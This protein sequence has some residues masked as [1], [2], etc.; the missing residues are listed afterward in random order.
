MHIVCPQCG[1][2]AFRVPRSLDG[3]MKIVC[4]SCGKV[5]SIDVAKPPPGN[6]VKLIMPDRGGAHGS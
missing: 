6:V 2:S 4:V 5:T 1:D 3:A